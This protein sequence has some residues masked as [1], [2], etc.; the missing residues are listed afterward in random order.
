MFKHLLIEDVSGASLN[1]VVEMG[2]YWG[3]DT[4]LILSDSR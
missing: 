4:I 2:S 1:S 3:I